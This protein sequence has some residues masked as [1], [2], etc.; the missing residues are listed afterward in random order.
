MYFKNMMNRKKILMC[1]NVI[2]INHIVNANLQK[3][4]DGLPNLSYRIRA[5][6]YATYDSLIVIN[7]ANIKYIQHIFTSED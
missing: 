3:E 2:S 4:Y 6:N 1:L 7:V 5:G